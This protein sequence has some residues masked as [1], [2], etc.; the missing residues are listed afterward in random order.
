MSL[1]SFCMCPFV[2]GSPSDAKLMFLPG[3]SLDTL[4][5]LGGMPF[6]GSLGL[7]KSIKY[8]VPCLG[9]LRVWFTM[10]L[11]K[12]PLIDRLKRTMSYFFFFFPSSRKA[13]FVDTEI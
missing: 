11:Y 4:R 9:E 8:L 7:L 6:C 1:G 2:P 13:L 12:L 5:N 3:I 10:T